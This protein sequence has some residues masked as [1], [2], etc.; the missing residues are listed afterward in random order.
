M[1]TSGQSKV[2]SIQ[3]NSCWQALQM[4]CPAV[5]IFLILDRSVVVYLPSTCTRSVRGRLALR[6]LVCV[7]T[8]CARLRND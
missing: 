1:G 6:R 5:S 2:G 4:A 7:T 8:A 3:F